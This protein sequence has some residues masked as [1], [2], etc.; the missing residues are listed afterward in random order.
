MDPLVTPPPPSPPPP[1]P[2]TGAPRWLWVLAVVVT[3][4]AVVVGGLV[5]GQIVAVDDETPHGGAYLFLGAFVMVPPALIA[6]V[7]LGI[8]VLT[9]RRSRTSV[10]SKLGL[11]VGFGGFVVAPMVAVVPLVLTAS[12]PERPDPVEPV[13]TIEAYTYAT[14]YTRYDGERVA[15]GLQPIGFGFDRPVPPGP[16]RVRLGLQRLL[17][18]ESVDPGIVNY[19]APA[20][21]A[22]RVARVTGNRA[23]LRIWLRGTEHF[24]EPDCRL[25]GRDERVRRQQV[26]WTAREN[27]G[28]RDVRVWLRL[29]DGPWGTIHADDGLLSELPEGG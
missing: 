24:D 8:A 7:L 1:A 26:A 21:S 2:S 18:W 25:T 12:E 16:G 6:V 20:C 29:D 5:V 11:A 3:T 15:A 9:R 23:E 27:A 14:A 10:S 19:W 17:G 22:S 28:S 4:G 13:E